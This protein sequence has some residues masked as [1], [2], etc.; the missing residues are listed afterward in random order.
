MFRCRG[1][2]ALAL[3][4][5]VSLAAAQEAQEKPKAPLVFKSDVALVAV[6][7]F[8]ID[9]AGHAVAGLTAAD[10]EIEEQGKKVKVVA[11]LPVDAGQAGA[12]SQAPGPI[13]AAARRQFLFLFDL[14][15]STPNG[16]LRA[17]KA[18]AEFVRE[19]LADGDLAAVATFGQ[20]GVSVLVGFT[21]D[22][23][24]VERA[25]GGL[26]IVETQ[27]RQRDVL[28][29]AYDLGVQPWGPGIGPPPDDRVSEQLIA[30]SR[31]MA[32]ADQA[33]YKQRVE[34]FLAGLQGLTRMLETVQGRKQVVLLS[35][36]FD[37]SVVSGAGGQEAS[38]ASEAVVE[39]R[40]W[41]VQSDRYFGDSKARGALDELFKAI[42]ATDSVIH[43][44][45]VT[46]LEAA[47]ANVETN[48]R[49]PTKQGRDTLAQIASN[50]G[51]RFV[52]NANDLRAGLD[53]LLAA[54]SHYYV[55]GFEPDNP[56]DKPERARKLKVRVK[57]DGVSVSARRGYVP[58]PAATEA[59]PAAGT[60][61][62]AESI[63]KG[64]SG[65]SIALS[66]V[67]VPY[68]NAKGELSLPV[69]LEADGRSLSHGAKSKQLGLEV[70][71]Y[72]FD[73]HGKLLDVVMLTPV[74]D[75][76][77][78]QPSLEAKGLQFITAFAVPKGAVDLRFLVRDK[79]SQRM[80]SLR[81]RLDVPAF[82]EGTLVLSPPLAIDDPR[83]RL[84]VPAPSRLRPAL[85]IPFRL[86]DAPFTAE[87]LPSL[88]N[89]VSREVC[90]M[91]W[92]GSGG[93]PE[94]RFAI[95][96]Q[97]V[98]AEG[99]SHALPVVAKRVVADADGVGRYVLTLQPKDVAPGA[100]VLR[101]SFR[102]QATGT[103]G[104]SELPVQVR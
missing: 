65:G 81:L 102:D 63:V 83:T 96:P 6:P 62:A 69:I 82:D 59:G 4:I 51:G 55:L 19:S 78:V 100:Y 37:S 84:V 34:G 40:I 80:G 95:E 26:G 25:I 9:K 35:A 29:I 75:L 98:D 22:R 7:V 23:S 33:F 30:M 90:V 57:R 97:L 12:P 8:V 54:T 99:G 52:S 14:M 64:L 72:A 13:Q 85:D 31:S 24:Q 88:A 47:G 61:R 58:K 49:Q 50:T 68:R 67:G 79:A 39:G 70:F 56:N 5:G 77:A 89:G 60:L 41:E 66:A 48:V 93:A 76:G 21:S 17:R 28:N 32:R 103:S 44:V 36:G 16:I 15:F 38:E 46:G 10:F 20:T 94:Q 3:A 27:P 104:L 74:I 42:A 2:I 87:P 73:G 43:T 1:R 18:A 91:A 11:F 101:V 92:G 53:E 86:A 71:G 45:D